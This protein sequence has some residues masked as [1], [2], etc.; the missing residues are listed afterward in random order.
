MIRAVQ[1]NWYGNILQYLFSWYNSSSKNRYFKEKKKCFKQVLNNNLCSCRYRIG[2]CPHENALLWKRT[3]IASFWPTVHT[4]PEN[5][6]PENA[7]F[8]NQVMEKSKNAALPFSCGRRICILSKTMKPS[9]HPSTCCLWPRNPRSEAES[10]LSCHMLRYLC[11]LGTSVFG[12]SFFYYRGHYHGIEKCPFPKQSNS[13]FWSNS[14]PEQK[15]WSQSRPA[16]VSTFLL[17]VHIS[18]YSGHMQITFE[19]NYSVFT[20]YFHHTDYLFYSFCLWKYLICTMM[21]SYICTSFSFS[22]QLNPLLAPH[23]FA[24]CTYIEKA[25]LNYIALTQFVC[26][27]INII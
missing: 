7:L 25:S 9:P 5:T 13:E 12:E 23:Q 21:S 27:I 26:W 24:K 1:K 15:I 11:I 14:A 17:R 8:W 18:K 10:V 6:A 19:L 4:D 22:F 16:I 2:G 3:H 20:V